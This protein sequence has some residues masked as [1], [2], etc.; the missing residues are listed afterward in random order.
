MGFAF[1]EEIWKNAVLLESQGQFRYR[2]GSWRASYSYMQH[3]KAASSSTV[4]RG[5]TEKEEKEEEKKEEEEKSRP[6]MFSVKANG[7]F[8][9]LLYLPWMCVT[10]PV[11]PAWLTTDNITRVDAHT[12]SQAV[13]RE[14]FET[15][16]LPVLIRGATDSWTALRDWTPEYMA[17]VYTHRDVTVNNARIPY[18]EYAHYAGAQQD[19][20]PLYMF[21]PY[22]ADHHVAHND[23]DRNSSGT[24]P[25]TGSGGGDAEDDDDD[26][27]NNNP[28]SGAYSVP[29]FFGEDAFTLLDEA[30]RPHHRW[31]IVGPDRSGSSFHKDPNESCA[32]NAVIRGTK[33]WIMYPPGIIPPGVQASEDGATVSTPLSLMEWFVNFYHHT[34]SGVI[35]VRPIEC[36]CREGEMVFVPRGW[37]HMVLNLGPSVAITQNFLP[38]SGLRVALKLLATKDPNLISGVPEADRPHLYQRMMQVLQGT[39]KGRAM[40][41][42]SQQIEDDKAEQLKERRKVASLFDHHHHR[43][44]SNAAHPGTGVE[45][46]RN[47][48]DEEDA[49]TK[50]NGGGF[51]FGF[52][53]AGGDNLRGEKKNTHTTTTSPFRFGF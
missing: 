18:A 27:A 33:K 28:M 12:L 21:D 29:S 47:D 2:G 41:Q 13:F 20:L 38:P 17:K 22:F 40:L 48:E 31:L 9:D 16:N 50:I 4:R 8:S 51:Q 6:R 23:H 52:P 44:P 7:L 11:D 3:K 24:G 35:P 26:E 19:E 14:R 34:K 10:Q 36:L 42:R 46:E 53:C 37:W 5:G 39:P 30:H 43:H 32:W 25:R 45:I 1:H 15:P 49:K